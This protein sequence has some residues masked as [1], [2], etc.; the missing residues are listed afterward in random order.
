MG[1]SDF[2]QESSL[3]G[4]WVH[5]SKTNHDDRGS[6]SEILNI[7]QMPSE[8]EGLVITQLLEATSSR[9]V[10]RGIHYPSPD[11]PQVKIVRCVQGQIR[12]VVI[13]LRT[14]SPT[15]GKYAVFELSSEIKSSLMISQGFGHAYQVLST[16]ATVVYALQTNFNFSQ[17]FSIN[18]LDASL[19]LP[20][21]KIAPVLSARD[22]S[23]PD[24]KDVVGLNHP[25]NS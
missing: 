19:E 20:W 24:F 13:D 1:D 10:I 14:D 5:H 12:D 11:N 18:P 8:F 25:N 15:F 4:V 22:A 7:S 9:G 16:D 6:T 23:A 3:K 21:A 2:F 17:E